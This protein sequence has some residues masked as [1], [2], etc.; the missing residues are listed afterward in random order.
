MADETDDA[1]KTEE[2]TQKKL[3]DAHKK[4]DV[5]K[6]QEVNS[7]FVLFGTTLVFILFAKTAAGSLSGSLRPFLEHAHAIP[8]DPAHMVRLAA[9]VGFAILAALA[10]PFLVLWIAA[11]AGNLIQH[12]LLFT[13][14]PI[15]PKLSKISP[16]AG[17]KRLFS[18]T[19][20]VNFAKGLAKL[21]VVGAVMVLIIWPEREMLG[22]LVASDPADILAL[23]R[24]MA[25]KMLAGVLI[26][27]AVV[28]VLDY[29]YQQTTWHKKQRMTLK[30]LRD[31]FKQME[32]D[33]AVRAKLRQIRVERGRK[34][35]MANVPRASVVITNPTHY[36][37]ALQYE[38]GMNAPVCLAKGTD[39]IALKIRELAREHDIPVVEN[40][41]LARTLHASVEIDREI[42]P[43]H[44]QA[45]AKVIG[46]VM[47][48][49]QKRGWKA[50]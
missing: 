12:R 14:E 32:G 34:R 10:L 23:V 11:V 2:P 25:L 21:G 41:P 49:R 16:K 50:R 37:V 28:A 40:P 42:A 46:Y 26:V 15:K 33:P 4:G 3:E 39:R 48:L 36:A 24:M 38:A 31:E 7:W 17:L 20:L 35:M 45:V 9:G 13:A 8:V 29:A 44:Y 47:Q 43:E 27:M 30:E 5:A 6:S 1:E 18:P 22:R 19:S